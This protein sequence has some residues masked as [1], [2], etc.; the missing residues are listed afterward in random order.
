MYEACVKPEYANSRGRCC[1]NN[2]VSSALIRGQAREMAL[3]KH[4]FSPY[5]R[6]ILEF[7][8]VCSCQVNRR[9]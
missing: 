1:R 4:K 3:W 8:N 5:E 2:N 6:S 7:D 9:I